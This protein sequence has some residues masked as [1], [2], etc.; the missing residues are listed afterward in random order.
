MEIET[1]IQQIKQL[2]LD[3]RFLIIE[4][5]L[6]SIKKEE[7]KDQINSQTRENYKNNLTEYIISEKSL[8][9]DWLSK[10]DR[11]WDNLF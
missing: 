4:E 11:R 7:L 2:P 9:E 5:A 10:D 1:I 3:K 8:A 6:N